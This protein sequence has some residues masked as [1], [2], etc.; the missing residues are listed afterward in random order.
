MAVK[1]RGQSPTNHEIAAAEQFSQV[2]VAAEPTAVADALVNVAD[3]AMMTVA[4]ASAAVAVVDEETFLAAVA[5]SCSA[6]TP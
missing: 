4:V 6:D 3:V 5:G 1:P 2:E